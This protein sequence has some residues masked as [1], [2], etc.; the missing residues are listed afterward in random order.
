MPDRVALRGDVVHL[1]PLLEAHATELHAAASEGRS[2][3]NFTF[4]PS[5]LDEMEEYVAIALEDERTGW[6]VPFVIRLADTGRI[7]G[8]TRFLD[9]AYW[10]DP[11]A[12]PPGRPSSGGALAGPPSVAE[13]GSTWLAASVQR[14][15]VNTETKLV[16]LQY[17]FE[18]WEV[19]RITLKTDVRNERSRRSIERLGATF[20]GVRRAHLPALD[21]TVRDSA[22]Y[23][24]IRDEWP[25]VL[26]GLQRRLATS[27]GGPPA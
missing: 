14:T 4:V 2:T 3:Y 25:E 21:G 8:T 20:E 5:T 13:I 27:P 1:D 22:F 11:P 16:M 10:T 24:I 23:S 12:W 26:A 19:H 7:V 17:A 18:V 9:L 6:A 15:A